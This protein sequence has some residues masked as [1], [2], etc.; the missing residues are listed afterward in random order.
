MSEQ[1]KIISAR[2]RFDGVMHEVTP[3]ADGSLHFDPPLA[4]GISST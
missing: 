3:R 4:F 1:L 2:V